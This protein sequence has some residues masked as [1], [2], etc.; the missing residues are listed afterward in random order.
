MA[1]KQCNNVINMK[2]A[3]IGAILDLILVAFKQSYE[4][5]RTENLNY[6]FCKM[7]A[8]FV[9]KYDRT[10]ADDCEVD[11]S[12]TALEWHPSQGFELL[13]A[14]L[15]GGATF[16]NLAKHPIPDDD[17]AVI[18]IHAIH[19]T[20]LFAEEYKAWITPDDK[21][22]NTKDFAA[23]HSFWETAVNTASVTATPALQHGHG[24]NAV[25]DDASAASLTLTDTGSNF[26]AAYAATQSLHNN[27]VSINAMQGQIQMLCNAIGNQPPAGMLQYPRQQPNQDCRARGGCRGQQQN[28]GQQGQPI[29]GGC[30][31][32]NGGGGNGLHRGNGGSGGYYQSSGMNFNAAVAYPTPG[33]SQAPPSPCQVNLGNQ[34]QQ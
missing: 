3:L 8:W 29:G 10:S 32:N 13:V 15:F 17:I 19:C 6:V 25:E 24:M 34:L 28:Q 2:S 20:G 5:I 31:T 12:A 16:A 18:G 33:T 9:T 14:R 7:F 21:P 27:N 11:G 1:L 23:F 30:G 26:G 4:Q 22:T